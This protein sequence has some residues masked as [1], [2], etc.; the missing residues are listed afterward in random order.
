MFLSSKFEGCQNIL[1]ENISENVDTAHAMGWLLH[2]KQ[3]SIEDIAS[4]LNALINM[5]HYNEEQLSEL[6]ANL[7]K[8][9]KNRF[10]ILE[11]SKEYI[12]N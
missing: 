9:R 7:V 8:N 4:I 1:S 3:Y 12:Q 6:I 2:R 5:Q 11:R 10:L